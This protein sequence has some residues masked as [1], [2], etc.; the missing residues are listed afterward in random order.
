MVINT[1][2]TDVLESSVLKALD[3]ASGVATS[4]TSANTANTITLPAVSGIIETNSTFVNFCIMEDTGWGAKTAA[5]TAKRMLITIEDT[6]SDTQVNIFDLAAESFTGATA[7]KTLTITGAATPTCVAAAGGRIGVTHED[8]VTFFDPFSGDW[9]ETTTGVH[10]SLS[11]STA[12]ALANNDVQAI[13][14]G[15]SNSPSMD[16]YGPIPTFQ[17]KYGSGTVNASLLK[18]DGTLISDNAGSTAD[19]A[20]GIFNGHFLNPQVNVVLRLLPIDSTTADYSTSAGQNIFRA[21]GS[22]LYGGAV[23]LKVLDVLSDG[24]MGGG[25]A[26]GAVVGKTSTQADGGASWNV[27]Y[28]A[29]ITNNSNTGMMINK[30]VGAWLTDVSDITLDGSYAANTLTHNG[31]GLTFAAVET[32][33]E[34]FAASGFDASNYLNIASNADWDVITTGTAHWTCW[35]KSSGTAALETLVA[36]GDGVPT[37]RFEVIINTDGTISGVDAGASATVGLTG[38]GVYDDGA[39]HRV[40][41]VRVSST[42]R[43]VYVDGVLEVSS[44]TNAGSLSSSGNLP[45]S[46]GIY[47]DGSTRPATSSTIA[48]PRL[49]VTAP[50]A[51]QV[52]QMYE[53]EK[54]MFVANAK[55]LLQGAADAVLDVSI[56]PHTGDVLVTQ[57]DKQTKFRGLVVLEERTIATGGTT[58]EHGLL[59]GENN[60]VVEINDA[61]LYATTASKDIRGTIA[62]V[63]YLK[64]VVAPGIDMSKAKAWISIDGTGTIGINSSYNIK[65]VTDNGT[66]QYYVYFAEHFKND[67][68]I[69]I[70]S[71]GLSNSLTANFNMN[72][73]KTDRTLIKVMTTTDGNAQDVDPLFV[74]WFGELENE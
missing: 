61:N 39:W 68:Y 17:V 19:N 58:F 36:F 34:L 57:A 7:L 37:I 32:S 33:A 40:D 12:P 63:E 10:K 16:N 43:H 24:R 18:D 48:L 73:V 56:N 28:A 11:T 6:G 23:T 45:L 49:S 20:I 26:S 4:A 52:R 44:T 42:E 41:L 22:G 35:F 21:D 71:C 47:P 27:G 5:S 60:D 59:F 30:T 72:G 50:S 51:A 55:C 25:S 29:L 64:K 13:K 8:G 31:G 46:I 54:G 66:G 62:D 3:T 69:I 53:A 2:D 14:V 1:I 70:A 38:T 9:A 74:L 15:F 67:D 65:S